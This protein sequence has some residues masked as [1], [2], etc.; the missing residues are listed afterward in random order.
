MSGL[1]FRPKAKASSEVKLYRTLS[2]KEEISGH[3]YD[4]YTKCQPV[5]NEQ[6]VAVPYYLILNGKHLKL[7]KNATVHDKKILL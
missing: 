1:I 3:S 7:P 2:P 6:L 4:L 5:A